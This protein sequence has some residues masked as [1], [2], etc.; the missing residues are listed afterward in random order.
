MYSCHYLFYSPVYFK[1]GFGANLEN[2]LSLPNQSAKPT[3]LKMTFDILS[4]EYAHRRRFHFRG[5][6]Y[7]DPINDQKNVIFHTRFQTWPQA[8][9]MSSLLS[10]ER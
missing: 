5:K 4:F 1:S 7:P 6:T 10:L 9:I 3:E 8:E 2:L